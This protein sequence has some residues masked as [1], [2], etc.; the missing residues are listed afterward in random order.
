M[1]WHFFNIRFCINTKKQNK[2][3]TV[4]TICINF[5]QLTT[6]RD[7]NDFFSEIQI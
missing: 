7:D 6:I 4:R 5:F 2:A 3:G 1:S